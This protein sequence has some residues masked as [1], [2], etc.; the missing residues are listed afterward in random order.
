MKNCPKL[1]PTG[2]TVS[3]FMCRTTKFTVEK[4]LVNNIGMV[5]L[6]DSLRHLTL[7]YLGN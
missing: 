3:Y 5:D 6:K 7:T 4:D 2:I 1:L